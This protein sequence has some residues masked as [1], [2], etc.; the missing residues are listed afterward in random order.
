MK[1]I[2]VCISFLFAIQCGA[3]NYND[4]ICIRK[5]SNI[6]DIQLYSVSGKKLTIGY[7]KRLAADDSLALKYLRKAQLNKF[8]SG[9]F[10]VPGGVIV[11]FSFGAWLTGG[12]VKS[13]FFLAGVGLCAVSIP[14]EIG[15]NRNLRKAVR[16]YNDHMIKRI[17]SIDE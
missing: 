11:G 3:Q 13:E 14:F 5:T 8:I 9:V 1:A 2:L 4:T 16:V 17:N 15:M 12:N 10:G 6:S 7:V